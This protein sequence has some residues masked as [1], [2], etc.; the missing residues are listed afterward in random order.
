MQLFCEVGMYEDAVALAL[1][2]D[3]QLATAIARRAEGDEGL[4]RKLWLAIARHIIEQGVGE[5][6]EVGVGRRAVWRC[7]GRSQA[8]L[9]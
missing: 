9:C 4:S 6:P 5:G 2:F 8:M 7:G 1:T 3:R